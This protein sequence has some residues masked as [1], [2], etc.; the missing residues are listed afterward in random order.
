MHFLIYNVTNI[1]VPKLFGFA[2]KFVFAFSAPPFSVGET[3]H[4]AKKMIGAIV[5][6]AQDQESLLMNAKTDNYSPGPVIGKF[7]SLALTREV[8]LATQSA[9]Q[10]SA[11]QRSKL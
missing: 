5:L 1:L 3:L 8:H 2:K 6:S 7:Q 9:T 10:S 4:V 11:I